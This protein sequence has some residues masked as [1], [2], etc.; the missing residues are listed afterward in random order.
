MIWT[1]GISFFTTTVLF[2]AFSYKGIQGVLNAEKRRELPDFFLGAG[3]LFSLL[4]TFEIAFYSLSTS[5]FILIFSL[6]L[7]SCLAYFATFPLFTKNI[8]VTIGNEALKIRTLYMARGT[9]LIHVLIGSIFLYL[10]FQHEHDQFLY[11][12]CVATIVMMGAAIFAFFIFQ[13]VEKSLQLGK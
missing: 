8:H 2:I 3:F 13:G 1:L 5:V 7:L 9:L 10:G 12:W 6:I 11:V 4:E